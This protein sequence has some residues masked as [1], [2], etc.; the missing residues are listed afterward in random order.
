MNGS[1][2]YS[3]RNSEPNIGEILFEKYC[4]DN[5]FFCTRIGFDEKNESVPEFFNL[6]HCMR[7]LPDYYISKNQRSWLV[8]VKGTGNIKKSEVELIPKFVEWYSDIKSPLVYAFCFNDKKPQFMPANKVIELYN[9]SS[10]R[11]WHDG[12]IYRNL[13]L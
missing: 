8:M 3:D 2:N 4:S 7:N 12:K 6:N 13:C 11:Q 9:M 5:G 10:D 1:N